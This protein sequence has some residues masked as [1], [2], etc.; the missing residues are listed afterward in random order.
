[1][2]HANHGK[3]CQV[4]VFSTHLCCV[5]VWMVEESHWMENLRVSRAIRHIMARTTT[6]TLVKK[7]SFLLIGYHLGSKQKRF[8]TISITPTIIYTHLI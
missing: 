5:C 4:I 6:Q 8:K 1:M 2:R 7:T 3:L